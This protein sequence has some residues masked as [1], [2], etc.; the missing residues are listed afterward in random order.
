M[1]NGK[2]FNINK[3]AK[4]QK[5]CLFCGLDDFEICYKICH[6]LNNFFLHI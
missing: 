3:E 5:N 4:L 1:T 6:T 2:L